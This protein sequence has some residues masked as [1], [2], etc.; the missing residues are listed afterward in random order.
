MKRIAKTILSS[1]LA[2]ILTAIVCASCV[3]A[4]KVGDGFL[5]KQPGVD[6]DK[7]FVFS[8]GESARGVLWT[9]YS[10]LWTPW[11]YHMNA[12]HIDAI[13]DLYHSY[14]TWD[15]N[16]RQFY[17]GVYNATE[18]ATLQDTYENRNA[19][20]RVGYSDK[21]YGV[22]SAVRNCWL[23]IENVDSVPDMDEAE[24]ARMK[25]EAKILIACRYYDAFRNLGGLPIIDHAYETGEILESPRATLEETV[26][27]MVGLLDEAIAEPNL[28]WKLT[29]AEESQWSGRLM[30]GSAAA[31]KAKILWY[32]ASPLFNSNERYTNEAPQ[33][34]FDQKLVWYGDYKESRWQDCLKACEYF[35]NTN[36][37]EA[38]R[39]SLVLPGGK[40]ESDY[41]TAFYKAYH[42]RGNS[43]NL[44]EVHYTNFKSTAYDWDQA[45]TRGNHNGS[46]CPTLE[47]M[48]MFPNADGTPFTGMSIYNTDNPDN[49]DIF[50]SRDPRLYETMYVQREGEKWQGKQRDFCLNSPSSI[51]SV[52]IDGVSAGSFNGESSGAATGMISY[53]FWLDYGDR[54]SADPIQFPYLR[55][56]DMYLVYAEALAECGKLSEACAAVNTVRS[57]VGLGKIET[58]NPNLS[59]T[60]NKENLINEILRER[61]CEFGLEGQRLGDLVRRKKVQD[62]TKILHALKIYRKDAP[63]VD[64]FKATDTKL[65]D[66]AYPSFVYKTVE[67]N[68]MRR[69]WWNEGFWTD[70]WLLAAFPDDEINKGYGLVQNPGW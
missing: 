39:Y 11:T 61:A 40:T 67:V 15:T 48:E 55:M 43:E 64:D 32:A 31:L 3:D 59:L 46:T 69:R 4:F 2:V 70:K 33:D 25:A 27:F 21:V 22:W 52:G 30:K 12:G 45:S 14:L 53:K 10:Y 42:N 54:L 36:A 49:I 6:T 41:R 37:T 24:K 57:R 60:S 68:V 51:Y 8:K 47:Y 66:V 7:A 20:C 56:A 29:E 13:T 18:E 63:I 38:N 17:S 9:A 34:A 1:C 65:T 19:H 28:P 16:T 23:F 44:I 50:A 26:N 35:F 58:C 62:F 5:E